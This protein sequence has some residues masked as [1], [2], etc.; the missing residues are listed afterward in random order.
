M[1]RARGNDPSKSFR[2][3][4]KQYSSTFEYVQ[5][6]KL[7][8]RE[9]DD[10]RRRM[11]NSGR[12]VRYHY[13]FSKSW[14]TWRHQRP[15]LRTRTQG[16]VG[17]D[18]DFSVRESDLPRSWV[19]ALFPNRE[20]LAPS[21]TWGPD[22]AQ[23]AEHDCHGTYS[24]TDDQVKL[25]T[26]VAHTFGIEYK[27]DRGYQAPPGFLKK[28]GTYYNP[29][30]GA[31]VRGESSLNF[32]E[33]KVLGLIPKHRRSDVAKIRR[34]ARRGVREAVIGS[35]PAERLFVTRY[36]L[37]AKEMRDEWFRLTPRPLFRDFKQSVGKNIT[38]FPRK[39][40]MTIPGIVYRSLKRIY[41]N[42]KRVGKVWFSKPEEDLKYV[43]EVR[44]PPKEVS[45]RILLRKGAIVRSHPGNQ[46]YG[47]IY[48]STIPVVNRYDDHDWITWE[49]RTSR[50]AEIGR[51][52][53]SL[54]TWDM[55]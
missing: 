12:N 26:R 31:Y 40:R 50:S 51:V 43:L 44:Q 3:P 27:G 18:P 54:S 49:G 24:L 21:H 53:R 29:R 34:A 4:R 13:D 15:L 36:R 46:A 1:S 16:V 38:L 20:L 30:T 37:S 14:R 41:S 6:L 10:I 47:N 8:V 48:A 9:W 52:N 45:R 35:I 33:K 42:P 32:P 5:D 39:C 11:Y 19:Y 55:W 28:L 23:V 2:F 17:P 7:A 25:W 22:N